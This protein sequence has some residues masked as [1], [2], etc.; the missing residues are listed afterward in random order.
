MNSCTGMQATHKTSSRTSNVL[1]PSIL[2]RTN[3]IT[4][5]TPV[6]KV[7]NHAIWPIKTRHSHSLCSTKLLTIKI[8]QIFLIYIVTSVNEKWECLARA[9]QNTECRVRF[10]RISIEFTVN[11]EKPITYTEVTFMGTTLRFLP[12]RKYCRLYMWILCWYIL[13]QLYTLCVSPYLNFLLEQQMKLV[14]ILNQRFQ[15]YDYSLIYS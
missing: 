11:W 5:Q 10:Y 2:L 3:R 4:V 15:Q 12:L 8:R 13:M 7:F 6:H 1:L 14:L 9:K